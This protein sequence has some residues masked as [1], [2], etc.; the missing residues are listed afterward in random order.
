MLLITGAH[1]FLGRHIQPYFPN[2]IYPKSDKIDLL[3]SG[4]VSD[5]VRAIRA[6]KI[7]HLAARCGGIKYNQDNP[8]LLIRDNIQM[9]LN[10]F[11]AARINDVEE[12]ITIGS[13]CQYPVGLVPPFKVGNMWQGPPE[14]T[15]GGYGIAKR[16]ICE[17]GQAYQTQYGINHKHII[18]ANL[19]GPGDTSNHVIPDLIRK[20][21]ND[22][23][24]KAWGD[25]HSKR[26]F[27][28]VKDAAKIIKDLTGLQ[29]EGAVNVGS[30]EI[31]GIHE[32]IGIIQR[33]LGCHKKIEY[34]MEMNGQR[35]RLLDS[36]YQGTTR[37]EDGLRKTIAWV[38]AN[39][40]L[41]KE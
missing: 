13:T 27:L 21:L 28:Y 8:A 34:S 12:V 22:D 4:I 26:E 29:F 2:A 14:P 10:V 7:L 6:R 19:Y 15:N 37:L 1:G 33:V 30:K 31:I 24:I 39:R 18:L 40:A 17:I 20:A 35:E 36:Q 3:K 5:Y 11:E 32:L 23:K 38:K 25:G 41:T 16:V 9:A